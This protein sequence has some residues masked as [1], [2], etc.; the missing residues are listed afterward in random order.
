M[1][2]RGFVHPRHAGLS[3]M[4]P[5]NTDQ[6]LIICFKEHRKDTDLYC[7]IIVKPCYLSLLI[8]TLNTF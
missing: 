3:S 7:N 2:L 8:I 6:P 4:P 5:V 1:D